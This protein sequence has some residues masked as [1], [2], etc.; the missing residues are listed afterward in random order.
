M[1]S[2]RLLFLLGNV[3]EKASVP[4]GLILLV[5]IPRKQQDMEDT[6]WKIPLAN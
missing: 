4:A 2:V 3:L 1:R 6:T 5:K